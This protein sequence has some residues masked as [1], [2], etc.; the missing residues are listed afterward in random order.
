MAVSLMRSVV[1]HQ[2]QPGFQDQ[3]AL[4]V[5]SKQKEKPPKLSPWILDSKTRSSV[6]TSYATTSMRTEMD[7]GKYQI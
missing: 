5:Y 7:T 6:M 2:M 4:G 3:I 1:P